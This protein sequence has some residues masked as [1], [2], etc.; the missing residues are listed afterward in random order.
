LFQAQPLD[1]T[2][3]TR[4]IE[5]IPIS[6]QITRRD[7]VGKS[8]NHLLSRPESRGRFRAIE[9]QDLATL[10]GQNQK[11]IQHPE[12]GGWDGKEIHCDQ[13][14]GRVL[15][16]GF[17][18]LGSGRTSMFGAVMAEGGIRDPDAQFSQ[19]RLDAPA[20]PGGIGLPQAPDRQS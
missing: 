12:G 2:R 11:D 19:F 9:R 16:E 15:K 1:A 20:A 14:L 4:V 13:C 10:M 17:P 7:S 5:G 8:S 18:G 6:E 3:E